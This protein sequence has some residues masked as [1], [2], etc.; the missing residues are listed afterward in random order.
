MKNILML[1]MIVMFSVQPVHAEEEG[2]A[3]KTGEGIKKGGDAAGRGVEKGV[4][5]TGRGLKKGADAT[6]RGIEKGLNATGRGL[7]KAGSWLE[8]KTHTGKKD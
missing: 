8:R 3:H 6:G 5:A 1:L 7:K 2:V 4:D